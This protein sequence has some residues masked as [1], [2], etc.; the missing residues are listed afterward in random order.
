MNKLTNRR[1]GHPPT[2]ATCKKPIHKAT[3]RVYKI[4]KTIGDW[5]VSDGKPRHRSCA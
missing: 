3:H 2:C 4:V 5:P 1:K